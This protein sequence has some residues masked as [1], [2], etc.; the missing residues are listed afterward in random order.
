MITIGKFYSLEILR[1]DADGV[2]L[3]AGYLGEVMLPIAE[4][5]DQAESGTRLEVFLHLDSDNLPVATTVQPK[6]QLDQCACL[7]VVACNRDGAFLDWGLPKD[8]F[9]PRK[10]QQLPMQVG[11]AYVVTVY[12]DEMTRR[13]AASSRLGDYLL[14]FSSEHKPGQRV[15]LLICGHSELGYKAVIDHT[16]LG[17]IY[18]TEVF[19][20]LK[21]GQSLT[22]YIKDIRPDH[23]IDLT[24]QKPDRQMRDELQQ[25]ILD[26]LARQAGH[27]TLNDKTPPAEI[28]RLFGVSKANF[29]KALGALYKQK[30]IRLE[31]DGIH[32]L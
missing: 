21:I 28:Y 8:L 6:V 3:D 32:L 18:H 7:N 22:G 5:P 25:K 9:V 24:L 23:R 29:K 19:Q 16:H 2:Y 13:L 12:L 11:R 31:K 17:L 30:K 10:Q 27:S 4:A 14:E 15:N 1:R 20:P 26:L